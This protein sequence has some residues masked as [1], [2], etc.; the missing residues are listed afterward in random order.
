MMKKIYNSDSIELKPAD[1]MVSE[2][3][4]ATYVVLDRIDS[5]GRYKLIWIGDDRD[6]IC[7]LHSFRGHLEES[8]LI[9]E[10]DDK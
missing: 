3:D 5:I 6:V 2:S 10:Y 9:L 4:N 8:D 1:I 7:D